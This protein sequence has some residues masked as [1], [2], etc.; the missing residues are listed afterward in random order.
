[1]SCSYTV[2][3]REAEMYHWSKQCHKQLARSADRLNRNIRIRRSNRKVPDSYHYPLKKDSKYTYLSQGDF[4]RSHGFQRECLW[5]CHMLRK[6]HYTLTTKYIN[7][8]QSHISTFSSFYFKRRV[9]ENKEQNLKSSFNQ[10]QTEPLSIQTKPLVGNKEI[11][12]K[13]FFY[14]LPDS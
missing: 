13:D 1:M 7:M 2:Q 6:T 8:F 9:Y 3:E 10:T 5:D 11:W 14:N 4:R 12:S